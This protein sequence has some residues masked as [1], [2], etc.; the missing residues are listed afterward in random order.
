MSLGECTDTLVLET[1]E[2]LAYALTQGLIEG[3]GEE[4]GIHA[5][6]LYSLIGKEYVLG[7]ILHKVKGVTQA[8][9][10]SLETLS[11]QVAKKVKAR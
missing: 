1:V 9:R 5:L 3:H 10:D 8:Q 2:N 4:L 7:S 6:A 11:A